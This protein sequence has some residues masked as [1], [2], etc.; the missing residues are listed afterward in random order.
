[1]EQSEGG[2]NSWQSSAWSFGSLVKSL[3]SKSEEVL[4]AYQR[5]L[6]EFGIG[7]KRETTVAA[8]VTAH[9]VKDLP[10]SLESTAAVAQ[11]SL[12]AVGQKLEDFGSSVWRGTADLIG[13]VKEAVKKVDEDVTENSEASSTPLSSGKG[14]YRRYEAQLHALQCDNS[15]Y[16][17]EPEDREDYA[18]WKSTFDLDNRKG[19]VELLMEE[20]PFIQEIHARIVPTSVDHETFWTRYFYRVNKLQQAED[21]RADLVKRANAVEEDLSWEVDEENDQSQRVPEDDLS[22]NTPALPRESVTEDEVRS[23]NSTSSEWLVVQEDRETLASDTPQSSLHSEKKDA[24][25]EDHP[26]DAAK[27]KTGETTDE[28]WG[29]WE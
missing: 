1:M 17:E 6:Q 4:Q 3:T 20:N 9:A 16:C 18:V 15:T 8:E 26:Q 13:Q 12:E 19:E 10:I 25:N 2:T 22:P 21:A 29:E 11:E 27:R 14:M 23:D 7:L 24:K 28:D 5:D